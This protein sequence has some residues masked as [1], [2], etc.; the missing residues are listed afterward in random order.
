MSQG[1]K[2]RPLVR[3]RSGCLCCRQRRKKCD[4]QKPKCGACVRLNYA[5]VYGTILS[6]HDSNQSFSS[7]PAFPSGKVSQFL[8]SGYADMDLHM[9]IKRREVVDTRKLFLQFK[10]HRKLSVNGQQQKLN[11]PKDFEEELLFEY[12][13]EVICRR[14]VFADS[15]FNEFRDVTVPRDGMASSLFQSIM[16]IALSDMERNNPSRSLYYRSMS[17]NYKNNAIDLLYDS[18]DTPNAKC[19]ADLVISIVIL[20]S[21]EIGINA[22]GNWV[23]HLQ[24]GCLIME[25]IDDTSILNSK[26]YLFGYKYFA[27]RYTLLLTTFNKGMYQK[28]TAHTLLK[29]IEEFFETTEIDNLFGCS[30]RLLYLIQKI[31]RLRNEEVSSFDEYLVEVHTIHGELENLQ[32]TNKDGDERIANCAQLYLLITRVYFQNLF[33]AVFASQGEKFLHTE[34][35][36]SSIALFHKMIDYNTHNSSL[37][38]TWALFILGINSIYK[39]DD[40]LRVKVL[41]I[42][43]KLEVLWPKLSPAVIRRAVELIWKSHDLNFS[44]DDR[45]HELYS[46][47]DVICLSGMQLALT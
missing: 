29:F 5:C 20:C 12:Y 24:E 47:Q 38:P 22:T 8:V 15:D 6:W 33:R 28:F 32:Q 19:M 42:F 40:V 13:V 23:N 14:K 1:R 39:T 41:E 9:A 7:G 30:P 25:S 11:A 46:W 21:L 3:T 2:R 37:F 35:V 4:E 26:V 36:D 27:L 16:A 31:V 10:T 17:M 45:Q 43:D 34:A 18:L 44:D